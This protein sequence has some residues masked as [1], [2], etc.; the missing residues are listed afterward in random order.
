[1]AT[2]RGP[3]FIAGHTKAGTTLLQALL[4]GHGE[5][6][7]V[8]VELKFFK[9][10][11]LPSLPPGNMPPPPLPEFKTPIPRSEVPVEQ[12]KDEILSHGD[13]YDLLVGK[14]ISRNIDIGDLAFDTDL[15][16]DRVQASKDET[17]PGLYES[18]LDAFFE[19][20]G[21]QRNPEELLFVEKTPNIEEYAQ[22][23]TGWFSDA[24]FVHIVRNPYANIHS[25]RK[26]RWRT[27]PLRNTY[28]AMAKSH[29]FLERNRRYLDQYKVVRYEDLVL[30]TTD[31]IR[32]I[33]RFLGI[34]DGASLRRPTILGQP[35][36][37]NSRTTGED[38]TGIDTRPVDAYKG[39]ISALDIALIN[40]F[41]SH[42]LDRYGYPTLG[43]PGMATWLPSGLESPY[44]YYCNRRLLVHNTL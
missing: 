23:L 29:Y 40:R 8:P 31:T 33:T 3:V 20:A 18:L 6:F 41:F 10:P 27:T 13:V 2:E 15:F 24:R 1:M 37:G 26:A 4:D 35:W 17:L 38:F 19:A 39:N 32:E 14:T 42:F 28:R 16:C 30:D 44:S 12:I 7:V 34:D 36:G 21:D 22:E 5:L 43:D 11:A 9:F 25:L